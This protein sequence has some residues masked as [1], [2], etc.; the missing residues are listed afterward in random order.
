M[1]SERRRRRLVVL[2]WARILGRILLG[3]VMGGRKATR[4]LRKATKVLRRTTRVLRRTTRVVLH[5]SCLK[6][7]RERGRGSRARLHLI[8]LLSRG[9]IKGLSS[10][11]WLL[12][13]DLIVRILGCAS[14][15]CLLLRGTLIMRILG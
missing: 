6:L 4:V 13:R 10:R 7:L 8:I 15:K 3:E 12:G 2:L 1:L 14:L 11:E 9:G 5:S